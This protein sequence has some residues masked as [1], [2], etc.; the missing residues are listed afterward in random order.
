[1]MKADLEFQ[2]NL[3]L[4]FNERLWPRTGRTPRPASARLESRGSVGRILPA[5]TFV[6]RLAAKP[7]M[8]ANGIVPLRDGIELSPK[9]LA[10]VR[11]KQQAGQQTFHRQ[12][13]TFHDGDRAVL[14]DGPV[15]RRLDAFAPAPAAEARTIELGTA[16]A[17]K[18]GTGSHLKT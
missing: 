10:A 16:V 6:G 11:D 13:E 3:G 14:A 7:G 18:G 5:I 17:N 2:T 1:M 4:A 9:A 12:D 8:R 15:A